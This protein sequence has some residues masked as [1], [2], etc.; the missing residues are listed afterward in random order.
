MNELGQFLEGYRVDKNQSKREFAKNIH[1]SP[2]TVERILQGE[3]PTIKTLRSISSYTGKT[4]LVLLQMSFPDEIRKPTAK[5]EAAAQKIYAMPEPR[6]SWFLELID[7]ADTG[8]SK[9]E[10]N[11]SEVGV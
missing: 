11:E 2:D 8:G 9:T 3:P 10:G 5:E 1:T 6:R 7:N 4:L